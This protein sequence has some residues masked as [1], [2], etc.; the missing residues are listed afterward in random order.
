MK[1]LIFVVFA[2]CSPV[3]AQELLPVALEHKS[4]AFSVDANQPPLPVGAEVEFIVERTNKTPSKLPFVKGFV[5]GESGGF[6]FI[7]IQNG[8]AAR[9][10]NL[11]HQ[12]RIKYRKVKEPSPDDVAARRALSDDSTPFQLA[13]R[14]REVTVTLS[15]KNEDPF[16]WVRGAMLT[17]PEAARR[18]YWNG[19][20]YF[21]DIIAMFQSAEEAKNGE[22]ELSVIVQPNDAFHL[23]QAESESRLEV[24]SQEVA[25]RTVVPSEKRCFITHRRGAERQR[26]EIPCTN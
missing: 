14:M 2:L 5:L 22:F 7:E 15:V 24:A 12:G 8:Y 4:V 25:R 26:I 10:A 3:Q 17:F 20:I 1:H 23:L 6:Y 13:P 9:V 21:A 18:N 11:V 16:D 19:D